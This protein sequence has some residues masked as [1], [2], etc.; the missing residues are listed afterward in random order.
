MRAF[1]RKSAFY[2]EQTLNA[3]AAAHIDGYDA[4]FRF[5]LR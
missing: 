5:M 3:G 2:A 1:R 4:R